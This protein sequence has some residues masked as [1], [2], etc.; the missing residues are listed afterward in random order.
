[1]FLEIPLNFIPIPDQPIFL[2]VHAEA[3]R[4]NESGRRVQE[5]T[6]WADGL[7]FG[8]GSWATYLSFIPVSGADN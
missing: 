2:A 8:A 3:V 1:M 6:A 7:P 4:R 5:E